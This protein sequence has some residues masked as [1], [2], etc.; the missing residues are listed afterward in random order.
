VGTAA[1]PDPATDFADAWEEFVLAI[2]RAQARGQ[3]SDE[4]LTLAQYYML[5]PLT[6]EAALPV[7][8]LANYAG[9]AAPT[10]TRMIDSLER[11]GAVR[12]E[13]THD[14]RRTVLIS[15]TPSGRELM[16][17]K[18]QELVR[19]RRALYERLE[20][21]D[22]DPSERLLRHLAELIGEL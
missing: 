3:Q 8:K 20:P 21:E 19:R 11:A 16:A 9:V 10:A 7:S 13:R 6:A 18:Q 5:N 22:R 14:D 4:D 17:R 12:R 1:D 15:L 2:R